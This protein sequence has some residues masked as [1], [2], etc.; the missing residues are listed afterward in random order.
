MFFWG[1]GG[2]KPD[3]I[4]HLSACSVCHSKQLLHSLSDTS[5]YNHAIYGNDF[6]K[7]THRSIFSRS[8]PAHASC[9]IRK[10][11]CASFS[12]AR[13]GGIYLFIGTH[14][15]MLCLFMFYHIPVSPFSPFSPFLP[16]L[17]SLPGIP[18]FPSAPGGPLGPGLPGRPGGPGTLQ[19]RRGAP[20]TLVSNSCPKTQWHRQTA[21]ISAHIFKSHSVQLFIS[22]AD[23]Y[24][25]C[26]RIFVL[27]AQIPFFLMI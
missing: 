24:S 23:Q 26:L 11:F 3:Y 16:S 13:T 21:P 14:K 15:L 6:F 25:Q 8:A 19:I 5:F 27:C 20:F 22:K 9:Q 7:G 10:P 12:L 17:P 4:D 2:L 1:V 18:T